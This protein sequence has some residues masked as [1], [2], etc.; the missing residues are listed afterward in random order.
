VANALGAV[1]AFRRPQ[2][3]AASSRDR[4]GPTV[5]AVLAPTD[6]SVG[7]PGMVAQTASMPKA[8][9]IRCR[10]RATMRYAGSHSAWPAGWS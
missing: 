6:W 3:S 4:R 8:R 1:A 9:P 7:Y 10:W 5:G 2:G